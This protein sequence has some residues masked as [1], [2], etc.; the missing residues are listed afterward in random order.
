MSEPAG[1]HAPLIACTLSRRGR[2]MVAEP[3]FEPGMA[4]TLG[5]RAAMVGDGQL[6]LV[7]P[8][9]RGGGRLEEELGPASDINVVM[10]AL[11]A[12]A[13][14]AEPWP[15]PVLAELERLPGDPLPPDPGRRDLRDRLTFTIDPDQARDFDD[16]LSVE[17]RGDEIVISV[18][19]ADVGAFVAEGGALDDEARWRSTSEY[20]PGRVDPMLPAAL[21]DGVCSLQP[22]RDRWALT[23]ELRES[24]AASF[25]RSLIQSDRRLTY[26]QADAILAG[27]HDRPDLVAALRDASAVAE[28]LRRGRLERGALDVEG[29]DLAFGFADGR[30]VAAR[31]EPG[32]AAHTLIEQL[33]IAANERVAELLSGAARPAVYRVHE[34]PDAEAMEAL[35]ERFEA[36]GVPTPPL[37]ELHTGPESAAYAGRLSTALDR[38]VRGSGRG[39][40]AFTTLLLRSLKQARYDTANLGHMGLASPAYCHFT[41]PIRRYPDL[42]CHRA[43]LGRLGLA[44]APR[45]D[46]AEVAE[47]ASA[48]EREAAA[49][50][51]RGADICLADL[52]HQKLYE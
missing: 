20:L 46:L 33:M 16:A 32:S 31:R 23:V 44:E 30:V 7:S 51:R 2:L 37:G 14:V 39:R 45:G 5:K 12:E 26:A 22:G 28:R 18:H 11:A 4:L 17:R 38:Y 35:V 25:S 47:H 43:L 21:S 27:A 13:G 34:P 10:H 19:I 41:S 15:E 24:G 36:L 8:R 52:L 42:V 1:G 9:G 29:G 49:L 48:F 40:A 50:E 6:V 3:Y